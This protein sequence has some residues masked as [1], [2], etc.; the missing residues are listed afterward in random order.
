M[1][2]G[3]SGWFL[4]GNGD[5]AAAMLR[6]VGNVGLEPHLML[7]AGQSGGNWNVMLQLFA[8]RADFR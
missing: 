6:C 8:D 5:R 4:I 3:Y 1:G 7:K 2:Y